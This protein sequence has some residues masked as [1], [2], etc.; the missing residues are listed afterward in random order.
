ML[1]LVP[2]YLIIFLHFLIG[3]EILHK[4]ACNVLRGDTVFVSPENG[5]GAENF[6]DLSNVIL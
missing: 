6:L 5:V 4:L 3:L 2:G 1:G